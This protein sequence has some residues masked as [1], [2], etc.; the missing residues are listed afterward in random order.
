VET[1]QQLSSV[2][3][4]LNAKGPKDRIEF[5]EFEHLV[6]CHQFLKRVLERNLVISQFT[7]F[8]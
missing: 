5:D 1:H 6:T 2:I 8:T 3:E 7:T 4:V